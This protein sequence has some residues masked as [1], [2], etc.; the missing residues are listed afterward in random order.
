MSPEKRK[1][2]TDSFNRSETLKFYNAELLE[3]ETDL[4]PLKFRKWNS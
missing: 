1:L 3:A 2:I 4:F